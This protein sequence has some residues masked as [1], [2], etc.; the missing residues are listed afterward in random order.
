M[1]WSYR[2]NA[3]H[4]NPKKDVRKAVGNKM[5]RKT[6][7]E[8]AGWRVHGPEKDGCKRMERQSKEWRGLEAYCR[9]GQDPPRAV[10]PSGGGYVPQ[11]VVQNSHEITV[12]LRAY[13]V[14][15]RTPNSV[16]Q[17]ARYMACTHT[18]THTHTQRHWRC[19]DTP[20]LDLAVYHSTWRA[21]K[22]S[23]GR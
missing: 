22:W 11:Y 21:R 5:K 10:A 12:L 1:A 13:Q 6:K 9:G 20:F 19:C 8:M 2:K 7:N 18:H 15:L 23:R 3:R 16:W 17:C 14:G 4:R